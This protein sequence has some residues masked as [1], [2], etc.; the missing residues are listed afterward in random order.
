MQMIRMGKLTLAAGR[1]MDLILLRF[2]Y[3]QFLYQLF[4]FV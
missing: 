4:S 3:K 2:L 1:K